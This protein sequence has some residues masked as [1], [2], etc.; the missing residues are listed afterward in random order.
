MTDQAVSTPVASVTEAAKAEKK[1]SNRRKFRN[2]AWTDEEVAARKA[3]LTV[4]AAPE[5][6]VKLAKVSDACR[7]ASIPVSKL[8]KVT[9]GDRCM[10]DPLHPIFKTVFVGRTRYLAPEALTEGLD[11]LKSKEFGVT[12]RAPR[13]KKEKAPDDG[14][15]PVKGAKAEKVAPKQPVSVR[16]TPLQGQREVFKK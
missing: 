14:T 13:V 6:W 9:G 16:A 5:G 3:A 4:E 2:D 15:G 8:V 10:G 12:P 1:A 7:A 11:L